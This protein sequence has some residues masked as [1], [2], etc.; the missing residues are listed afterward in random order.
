MKKR[1][2]KDAGKVHPSHCEE[3]EEEPK[4]LACPHATGHRGEKGPIEPGF[5]P[6]PDG[7]PLPSNLEKG[8]RGSPSEP[9]L[10]G[11]VMMDFN[12]GMPVP[13]ERERL[14]YLIEECSEVQKAATKILRHGFNCHNPFDPDKKQNRWNLERELEDLLTAIELLRTNHDIALRMMRYVKA[15]FMDTKKPYFHF[16]NWEMIE[17]RWK[18]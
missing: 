18:E 6:N 11:E 9:G 8:Q 7:L 17:K 2:Y 1:K 3:V 16:Q 10:P 13:T 4:G 14:H 12:H 15:R 5:Q